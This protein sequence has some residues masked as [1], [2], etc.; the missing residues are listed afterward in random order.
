MLSLLLVAP[1][2]PALAQDPSAIRAQDLQ[3][4]ISFLAS[5]ALEGRGSGTHGSMIASQY[6]AQHWRRFGLQPANDGSYFHEFEMRSTNGAPQVGRNT[7]A[8]L[9]GTDPS[10]ANRY[11]VIG[12]HHDHAGLGDPINGAMGFVGEIHNG[13]DDNASGTS[14]ALELAEYFAANPLRHP[15]LFVTFDAEE[16]GLLGSE[17]IVRDKVVDPEN[18]LFMMNLDM[19]GRLTNDYLF[20]GGIGTAEELDGLLKPIFGA[21]EGFDFEFHPGGEAPSDNTN[22]YRAGVPA[23]FF[24]THIHLDYHLPEDDVDKINYKG[25]VRILQLAISTLSKIDTI[26]QLTYVQQTRKEAAGTPKDF[27]QRMV[28]HMRNIAERREKR[29]RL[30]VRPGNADGMGMPIESITS[31]SAAELAGLQAN[32]VL[33]SIDGFR[34][35]DRDSLRRALAGKFKGTEIRVVFLRNGERM[36]IT[37]TMK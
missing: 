16:R 13:A 23:M 26:D 19:I 18:M 2:T 24:F 34:T 15:I 8:I 27:S 28:D 29:G 12:A 20:V 35:V 1:I 3:A 31:E 25:A 9:P 32:D 11:I 6:V 14:G 30:G 37:A 21:T 10:V 5:D 7:C 17:A 22:Y 36:S 33:L 4:H